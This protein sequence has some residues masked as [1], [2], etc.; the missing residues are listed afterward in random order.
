MEMNSGNNNNIFFNIKHGDFD[1]FKIKQNLKQ[2]KQLKEQQ[3]LDKFNMKQQK[4]QEKQQK[5]LLKQ[6]QQEQKELLRQQKLEQIQ[7]LKQQKLEQIQLLKQQNLQEKQ[8]YKTLTKQQKI[9]YKE[10]KRLQKQQIQE[11]KLIQQQQKL[12]QQLIKNQK[13]EEKKRQ[14][15]IKQQKLNERKNNVVTEYKISEF[16]TDEFLNVNTFIEQNKNYFGERITQLFE[17]HGKLKIKMQCKIKA[18]KKAKNINSDQQQNNNNDN[19]QEVKYHTVSTDFNN[20]IE[21][22]NTQQIEK[23]FSDFLQLYDDTLN[24]FQESDYQVEANSGFEITAVPYS[25]EMGNFIKLPQEILKKQ[26][27]KN[28]QNSDN[29]CLIYCYMLKRYI[30]KL[31]QNNQKVDL[32]HLERQSMYKFEI[33]EQHHQIL[34]IQYHHHK[35]QILQKLC[36]Y[37]LKYFSGGNG[38]CVGIYNVSGGYVSSITSTANSMICFKSYLSELISFFKNSINLLI[39][40]SYAYSFFL[41]FTLLTL[42]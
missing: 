42:K 31:E 36:K 12:E 19:I 30:L 15:L 13:Q 27:C 25:Q 3:K 26:A 37:S 10:Q 5:Q 33:K 1:L 21:S 22:H 40:S 2:L 6:Q 7:L 14:L 17:E 8:A 35:Q 4:K 34:I 38:G 11:Q 16:K 18:V 29:K 24:K 41:L 20:K 39:S 23:C 9:Q 32:N 28:I